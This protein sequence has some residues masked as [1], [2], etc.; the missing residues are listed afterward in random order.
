[1]KLNSSVASQGTLNVNGKVGSNEANVKI[2]LTLK[3]ESVP[4]VIS[5]MDLATNLP[6]DISINAQADV[7]G[8]I[9]ISPPEVIVDQPIYIGCITI[10]EGA[11]LLPEPQTLS[12]HLECLVYCKSQGKHYTLIQDT[13]CYCQPDYQIDQL[14]TDSTFVS[15][16]QCNIACKSDPSNLCGGI[17]SFSVYISGI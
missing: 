2:S 7:A 9:L 5:I 1:M 4:L 17:D 6:M 14:Y 15:S 16:A 8:L 12:S 11:K 13:N 10:L 3:T